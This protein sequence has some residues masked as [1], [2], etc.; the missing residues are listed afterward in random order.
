M[1]EQSTPQIVKASAP[2]AAPAGANGKLR[3]LRPEGGASH[4]ADEAAPNALHDGWFRD[5]DGRL[6]RADSD[7]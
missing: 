1:S 7:G 6:W 3:A 2:S 4:P 5:V